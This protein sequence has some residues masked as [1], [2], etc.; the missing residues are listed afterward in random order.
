VIFQKYRDI[1]EISRYIEKFDFRYFFNDSIRYIDIKSNRI[2]I[3]IY[4]VITNLHWSTTHSSVLLHFKCGWAV[5]DVRRPGTYFQGWTLFS[6]FL[7][8][9]CL[10]SQLILRKISTRSSATAEKQRVSC[11]CLPRLANWSCNA[12]NSA[13]SQRLYYFWHSNALDSRSAGRKRI[14]SRNSCSRSFTLLSFASRQG[15]AYRHILLL[16][17]SLK[18]SKT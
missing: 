11:S 13:E 9:C 17:V 8:Q 12:Q 1:S 7:G 5:M 10:E 18:F 2:E 14:L 16:A 4:R 3:L 15:V 6:H